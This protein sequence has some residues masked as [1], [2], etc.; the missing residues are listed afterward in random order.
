MPGMD[1]NITYPTIVPGLCSTLIL[2]LMAKQLISVLE[3]R[4]SHTAAITKPITITTHRERILLVELLHTEYAH[5]H[6]T[7][8]V[9]S[10]CV[11]IVLVL[12]IAA[13]CHGSAV[14]Q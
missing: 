8:G 1:L 13:V 9:R 2:F 10:L 11:V 14:K 12:V 6:P 3:L 7:N 4:L 5:A